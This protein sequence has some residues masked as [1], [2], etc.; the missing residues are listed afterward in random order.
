MKRAQL[1]RGA[2]ASLREFIHGVEDTARLE[3]LEAE[4]AAHKQRR[5]ALPGSGEF[6][7]FAQEM[8]Q[9]QR[10]EGCVQWVL[11]GQE[12]AWYQRRAP[13]MAGEKIRET[14]VQLVYVLHK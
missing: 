4:K 9:V 12:D 10:R 5:R 7:F 13:K 11:K 8:T 3:I 14:Q 1:E 6:V 2:Y